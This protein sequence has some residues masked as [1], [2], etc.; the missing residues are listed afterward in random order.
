MKKVVT[1]CIKK[2]EKNRRIRMWQVFCRIVVLAFLLS[3]YAAQAITFDVADDF[4]ATNNPNGAWSYGWSSTLTSALNQYPDSSKMGELAGTPINIDTWSNW[5]QFSSY[6]PNVAHNGTGS[7]NNEHPTITWQ[8]GQFSLHPGDNGVYSHA[9]W[10]ATSAGTIDIDAIF[11]GID[12][13]YGTTTD[14]HV[15]YNS[16]SLFDGTINGYGNTASFSTTVSVG[17]GDIIDFAVGDGGNGPTCDTTA[18]SAT[19]IPEPATL[20]LLGLGGLALRAKNGRRKA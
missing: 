3:G 11:T 5:G 7:I 10:T 13:Y 19:I 6:S 8:V 15:F 17:M 2:N 12:Y 16:N 1:I 4:S 9:R 14:V 20:L 18:L